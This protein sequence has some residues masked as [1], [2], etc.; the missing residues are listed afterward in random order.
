[1]TKLLLVDN[2]HMFKT[3]DGEYY[4]PAIYDKNFFQRYLNVFSQVFVLAKTKYVNEISRENYIHVNFEGVQIIELP[5]YKGVKELLTNF[6]KIL[7]VVSSCSRNCDCLVLR[8]AQIESFLV[9]LAG[10]F[11][12]KPYALE[13]VNDPSTFVDINVFFRIASTLLL[14]IMCKRADGVS[15][16]TSAVLQKK[17][18]CEVLN[19]SD[20]KN[21][22]YSSYSS[23]D[24]DKQF[25]FEPKIYKRP[26]VLKL[27]H[28]ANVIDGESKGYKTVIK[29]VK[30][31]NEEKINTI[32]T[33]IGDGPGV[34]FLKN[35]VKKEHL[36]NKV[37][38]VGRIHEKNKYTEKLRNADIFVFPSKYEGL[39]RVLI[40][41]MA[42]GLPCLASPVG[43]IVELLDKEYLIP[44][45]DVFSYVAKIKKLIENHELL[46]K[47]S[48]DNVFTAKMYSKERLEI[49][50]NEFYRKLL[51]K[52]RI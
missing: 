23:I 45:D 42:C 4:T 52:I 19:T 26:D 36:E 39:P 41:A 21:R 15:Y 6:N 14:K 30:K 12:N 25:V 29:V 10:S 47:M 16:V 43:G 33:F 27:V 24:L 17:Y 1:M 31:L 7:G 20:K 48:M 13:V 50:R 49:I 11:K 35:F 37:Y 46:T 22:F 40:E 3:P 51:D 8:V 32:I 18:P 2:I 28:V 34:V 9:Y 44:S 5:W 38:F